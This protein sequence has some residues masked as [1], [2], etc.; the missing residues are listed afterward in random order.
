MKESD[1]A[2]HQLRVIEEKKE[3]DM[4]LFNLSNFLFSEKFEELEMSDKHLLNSQFD[5]MR[6]YSE[7]LETRIK[8]F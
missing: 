4:K 8:N 7:I 2:P 3:L 6:R 5:I 1:Y